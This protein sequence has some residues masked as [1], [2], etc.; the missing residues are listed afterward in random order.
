MSN[1]SGAL[2]DRLAVMRQRIIEAAT[3]AGRDNTEITTIIVTK[4]HPV[5]MIRDLVALGAHDFG[6]SRHQE[7]QRKSHELAGEPIKWHFVGQLQSKKARQ[8]ASYAQVI[9]SIDRDSVVQALARPEADGG[10][11]E[12]SPVTDCFVQVNLT[13]DPRRGGVADD[14]LEA[15]VE[16]VL[17]T[18]SL[19][20]L[21]V[22]AVAPNDEDPDTAF[23]QVRRHSERV[24]ALAPEA[25]FISAGMSH[26][27]ESAIAHGA[28]HLRIGSAITGNR[29]GYG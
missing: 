22:M 29:P 25:R 10:H 20:L 19:N 11:G 14:G 3:A 13:D 7:A 16:R 23:E 6:E 27:F 1:E 18:D 8:A 9:H 4:F 17:D 28:T 12:S 5:S 15:L 21:G 24:Q 26:D 2:A